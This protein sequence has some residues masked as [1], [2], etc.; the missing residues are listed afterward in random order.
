MRNH[1]L[2]FIIPGLFIAS[3]SAQ[4]VK[5]GVV[6]GP[7][8][9]TTNRASNSFAYPDDSTRNRA[10]TVE[11]NFSFFGG[12]V[13]SIPISKNIVVKPQLQY[14]VKGWTVNHDFVSRED[15][16]T[17]PVSHWIELLLNFVYAVPAKNGRF[18]FGLGPQASYALSAVLKDSRE[19]MDKKIEFREGDLNDNIP[20]ANR[21][22]VGGNLMAEYEFRNGLF[23]RLNYSRGF[24]DFRN[25][26]DQTLNPEN[27]NIVVGLGIGYMFK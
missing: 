7:V 17:K 19:N 6:A 23:L 13:V 10:T 9:T 8:M 2:I 1:L 18:F 27:K 21:F 4:K 12:M 24:I 25:D 22:D 11:S 14:I 3:V 26:L 20:T 16:K 5:I 15:Y